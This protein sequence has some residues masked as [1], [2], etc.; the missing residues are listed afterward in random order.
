MSHLKFFLSF[1]RI[2]FKAML[3]FDAMSYPENHLKQEK[4]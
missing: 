1:L 2:I 4:N 3:R